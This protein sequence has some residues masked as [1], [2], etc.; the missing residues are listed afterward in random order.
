[1]SAAWA[2]VRHRF[3]SFAGMFVAV[4]LGV[5]VV[6]GSAALY[7]SSRPQAPARYDLAPVLITPPDPGTGDDR[8]RQSWTAAQATAL[9]T[10]LAELA[11]VTA[12]VPDPWFYVQRL[13]S[14]R[15]TGDAQ[16]ALLD[17]HAWSSAA[18]GGYRLTSGRAP[19]APGEVAAGPGTTPGESVAVLTS[20]GPEKW[21]VTGT[22]DGPG[23]YVTD[24][25]AA[26]RASGV[27]VIGLT[28]TGDPQRVADAA[29][30][31]V[32]TDGVVRSGSDRDAL[33]PDSVTRIR[34]IGAQLLIA[35]VTLGA[36]ATVFVVSSTCAL[37]AA[38]RRRELGLLRA[39]GA[40]P[41]QVRRMMYAETALI[42]LL[43]GLLGA[44]AG[45][46]AAPLL[47]GPMVGNGLEPAGFTV[48]WQ[49]MALAGAVLL[50]LIVALGGVTA[51]A[52]RASR[53]APLDALREAA[54]DPRSMTPTR[55]VVGFLCGI[56]GGVLLAAMPSLPLETRSTAGLGAAMLL[57][58]GAALLSPV[59]IVPLVRVVARPWR[60]T[61]TGMLVREGTLT[62]VRR[63][64]STAAPVLATVG[65]T[66]LLA[67]TVA[68]IEVAAGIDETARYPEGTVL[69]PDGTPGLSAAAV[70]AQGAEPALTTRLLITHGD[71]TAGRDATGRGDAL[72]LDRLS[73]A[74]LGVAAGDAVTVRFVDGAETQLSVK[75][76]ADETSIPSGLVRQHDPD[77]L[78]GMIMLDR[79][80]VPVPGA[81]TLAIHDFV[82]EEIEDE[83]RLIDLFLLALIGLSAGYTA[84]A[85]G[86]TL[87]MAT[88]ARRGEFRALRLAGAGTGQVVRVVTAEALLAVTVGAVLGG[89][90][91]V[92]SLAGVR[93]AVEDEIGREIALIMPWGVTAAVTTV[94]AALA[95]LAASFP[96]LR[97]R[98][99]D[100]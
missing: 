23:L 84:I 57:L 94:C 7:L 80:V 68:T 64:A 60:G 85:V 41:G 45:L 15:P 88:A 30:A 74:E 65:L 25:E 77:A 4:F 35:L 86:N 3:A 97:G 36:F 63:V 5:A 67:G 16:A 21:L 62:G 96:I 33:E 92:V 73:A 53:I 78:T 31:V 28:V 87:L 47:A 81:R 38:Q 55:W 51:A 14:G 24:R 12:A 79:E 40:T 48:T 75:A 29:A 18:L 42:A 100:S 61:A 83:G 58:S 2:M 44:P 10:R 26:R 22:V 9:A 69:V 11:G 52:R 66:V 59:L 49:P 76:V 20:A 19:A 6:A 72:V 95:V 37:S 43:A 54:A 90:V 91:A 13:E 34:W 56:G 82:M 99:T 71:S 50:G 27:R 46:M 89:L 39:V 17:G 93:A 98:S 32:G 1:M 8:D 70:T